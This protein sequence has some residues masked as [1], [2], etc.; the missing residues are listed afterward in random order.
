MYTKTTFF[1][2]LTRLLAI[3]LAI[4]CLLASGARTLADSFTLPEQLIGV[5]Q[6]FLEFTVEDYMTRTQT[7]GRYD[8]QVNNLDPRLRMPVC[9]QQ[10]DASLESPAQPLGRVTVRVRCDGTSPWTVFVP[11]Q[12]KLFRDV[13]VMTRPLKRESVIT[14]GDVALRERDVSTL[15]QGFL[16]ELDQAVGMKLL[17]PT[18]LDQVLTLQQLEQA[19]V[20]RKGDHVV[21]TARSGGL[22]VR[23]PGEALSKGG[24]TEQIRVRNL[25]SQ[26]VVKATVVGPGQVEVAM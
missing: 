14:E 3:P 20:I 5:T 22:S 21:I 9:S 12:V 26:R 19:D 16:S 17:R 18:V 8:I 7:V 6:G 24:L 10:L 2:R 25:N 15:G 13:V 23:M 4:A 1:R 11:A